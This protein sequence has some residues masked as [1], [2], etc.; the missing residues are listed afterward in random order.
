M[1]VSELIEHLMTLDLDAT[2][3]HDELRFYEGETEP[4]EMSL[5]DVQSGFFKDQAH[6]W[7]GATTVFLDDESAA[8]PMRKGLQKRFQEAKGEPKRG[9]HIG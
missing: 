5:E 1:K 7:G 8:D 4:G 9:V 3:Y 6:D 2:V